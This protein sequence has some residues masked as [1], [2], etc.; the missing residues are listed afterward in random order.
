MNPCTYV[1][2]DPLT[3][4]TPSFFPLVLYDHRWMPCLFCAA[5]NSFLWKF[6]MTRYSV[7]VL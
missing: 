2:R 7:S 5:P 1:W 3:R 4:Q 6:T